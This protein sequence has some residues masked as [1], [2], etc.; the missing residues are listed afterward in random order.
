MQDD[1]RVGKVCSATVN[2]HLK[3]GK[4]PFG[5][6]DFFPNLKQEAEVQTPD[7]MASVLAG[8]A[9]MANEKDK[10]AKKKKKKGEKD[11]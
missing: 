11:G 5:P 9:K 7:Q 1:I 8:I 6:E 4:K 10:K 2:L 3:K